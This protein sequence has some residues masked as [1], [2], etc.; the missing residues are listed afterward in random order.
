MQS[1]ISD[2]ELVTLFWIF[3]CSTDLSSPHNK[4]YLICIANLFQYKELY[5]LPINTQE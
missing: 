5:K 1:K 3:L 4:P 2:M